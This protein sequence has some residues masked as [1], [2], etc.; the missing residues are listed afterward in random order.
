MTGL[1]TRLRSSC[2]INLHQSPHNLLVLGMVFRQCPWDRFCMCANQWWKS[3]MD[4][5]SFDW[6]LYTSLLAPSSHSRTVYGDP[7]RSSSLNYPTSLGV[8]LICSFELNVYLSRGTL[9]CHFEETLTLG[10][11]NPNWCAT[12]LLRITCSRRAVIIRVLYICTVVSRVI[13]W[14]LTGDWLKYTRQRTE[15]RRELT[16]SCDL[17]MR[18]VG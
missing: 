13:D 11:K 16:E 14:W 8:S 5:T 4:V 2:G 1:Q 12:R 9:H 3:Y 6:S 15:S 17:E 10:Y 7:N 18:W